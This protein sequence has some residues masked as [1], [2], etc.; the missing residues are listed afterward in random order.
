MKL[1]SLILFGQ[2]HESKNKLNRD[3]CGAFIDELGVYV[4]NADQ[5]SSF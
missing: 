1:F 2:F 5:I 3:K 4:E